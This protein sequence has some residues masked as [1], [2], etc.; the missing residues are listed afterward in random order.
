M[1]LQ[2][3]Y[4]VPVTLQCKR[5][6]N[7]KKDNHLLLSMFGK[8]QKARLK[9]HTR[10]DADGKLAFI[11]QEMRD[12]KLSDLLDETLFCSYF[13]IIIIFLLCL[14]YRIY[15]IYCSESIISI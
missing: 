3:F 4:C 12:C 13:I 2:T 6:F 7:V 1:M 15:I 5:Y 11:E 8:R 14:I 10:G 9:Y